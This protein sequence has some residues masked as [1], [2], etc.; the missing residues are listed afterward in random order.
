MNTANTSK[1][2]SSPLQGEAS[3]HETNAYSFSLLYRKRL[4]PVAPKRERGHNAKGGG[5]KESQREDRGYRHATPREAETT[6]SPGVG[7]PG[8]DA[9][10]GRAGRALLV[11]LQ[12]KAQFGGG[13]GV[14]GAL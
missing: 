1:K 3:N 14:E 7:A 5:A 12:E 9:G 11:G 6:L 13:G 10:S 2:N 8:A 4:A